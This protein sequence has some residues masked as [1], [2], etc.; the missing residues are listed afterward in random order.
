MIADLLGKADMMWA[1]DDGA[2]AFLS[3]VQWVAEDSAVTQRLMSST[4]MA[5]FGANRSKT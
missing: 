5:T 4:K 1:W 3:M 2:Y